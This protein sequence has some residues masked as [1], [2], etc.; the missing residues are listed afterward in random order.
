M[1]GNPVLRGGVGNRAIGDD[2]ER[3]HE[4]SQQAPRIPRP[5]WEVV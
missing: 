2:D 4:G 1:H 3:N 5:L